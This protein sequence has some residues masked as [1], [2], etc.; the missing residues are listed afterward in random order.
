MFKIP[1]RI[2]IAGLGR[3]NDN[4]HPN[5]RIDGDLM[6]Y[7]QTYRKWVNILLA[8]NPDP[9]IKNF[10][11]K[12]RIRFIAKVKNDNIELYFYYPRN[13]DELCEFI[14]IKYGAEE[15]HRELLKIDNIE[16]LQVL[17]DQIRSR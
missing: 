16:D 6:I 14:E 10:V 12:N 13:L 2:R 17:F 5:R 15:Y 8:W 3:S 7:N 9:D 11:D 1:L 4:K